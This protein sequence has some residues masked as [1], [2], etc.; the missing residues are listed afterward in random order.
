MEVLTQPYLDLL[1]RW[2]TK[3]FTV[4]WLHLFCRKEHVW[5]QQLNLS[6]VFHS[7]STCFSFFTETCVHQTFY[8]QK[9]KSHYWSTLPFFPKGLFNMLKSKLLVLMVFNCWFLQNALQCSTL[10]TGIP[11]LEPPSTQKPMDNKISA[12]LT[13]QM[14][15]ELHSHHLQRVLQ[16]SK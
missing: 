11:F 9:Q 6:S 2:Y 16:W 7:Y 8:L 1:N 10:S 3:Q 14:R 13:L 12:P 5:F 4:V 15:Q